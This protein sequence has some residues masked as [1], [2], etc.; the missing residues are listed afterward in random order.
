MLP[1][2]TFDPEKDAVDSTPEQLRSSLDA[3]LAD[4]KA[5]KYH[6]VSEVINNIDDG[7]EDELED[8]NATTVPG[9]FKVVA[10]LVLLS[11]FIA[12]ILYGALR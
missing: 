8:T 4:L 12:G 7:E 11:P 1:D 6:D 2:W 9:W 10:S 5:G 3:S